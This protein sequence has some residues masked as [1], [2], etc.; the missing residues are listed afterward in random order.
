MYFPNKDIAEALIV[1][2]EYCTG[3]SLGVKM[4]I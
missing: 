4:A 2:I 3:L 1:E